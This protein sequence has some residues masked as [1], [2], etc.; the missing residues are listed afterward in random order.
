MYEEISYLKMSFILA[1]PLLIEFK[2]VDMLEK[3]NIIKISFILICILCFVLILNSK[4]DNIEIKYQNAK[5]QVKIGE[6]ISS[7]N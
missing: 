1:Y 2:G 3:K 5:N 4:N 6:K 7:L